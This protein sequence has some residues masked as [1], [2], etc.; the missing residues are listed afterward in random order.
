MFNKTKR[1]RSQTKSSGKIAHKKT[2]IDN[3]V[4]DSKMESNYYLYL[5]QQVENKTIKSFE[6][7]PE[8]ILQP[9]FFVYDGK[10]ITEDNCLYK[11]LDKLRK[12]H[13]KIN[14]DNKIVIVKAIKYISDFKIINNDGSI[15]IID[16]KGIKT[17]DFKIKEKMFKFKYPE[18]HLECITWNNKLNSWI[19]YENNIKFKKE[20]K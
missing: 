18:Y 9:K 16:I 19:S 1:K 3:I 20:R 15:R 5:K 10:T 17:T 11:E 13:N 14:A 4:F 12:Q 7:Q 8:F 6:L 2:T